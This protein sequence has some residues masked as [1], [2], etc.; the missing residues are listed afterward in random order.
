MQIEHVKRSKAPRTHAS[1]WCAAISTREGVFWSRPLAHFSPPWRPKLR[2]DFSPPSGLCS[3]I[4]IIVMFAAAP[5][6]EGNAGA[7]STSRRVRRPSRSWIQRLF[8]IPPF[9]FPNPAQLVLCSPRWRHLPA[10]P[11]ASAESELSFS[12]TFSASSLR[13]I[14]IA[15]ALFLFSGTM[16][17]SC[18]FV[19]NF[20]SRA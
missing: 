13:A 8:P 7:R 19:F 16:Y 14:A 11:C 3:S 20:L 1:R 9:C 17:G 5:L 4:S 15:M 18:C 6:L 2:G 10:P 12:T